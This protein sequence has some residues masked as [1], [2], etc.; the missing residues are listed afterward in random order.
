VEAV[1]PNIE[2]FQSEWELEQLV[3]AVERFAPSS[4]L[5]VGVWHGGT[6]WHWLQIADIVV[7]VDDVMRREEDWYGWADDACTELVTV[8]GLSRDRDVIARVDGTYDFLFIDADH[9]YQSVRADWENYGPMVAEGGLVA[10][11]DILPRP[12]YG[13]SELWAELKAQE[14]SRWMEIC[15]NEVLPGNEGRCGIGLLYL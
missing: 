15:Q 9:S 12:G 4:V 13:V 3:A 10:F 5:E 11:H 2:T 6:L 8:Q 1:K 14:G 7:A